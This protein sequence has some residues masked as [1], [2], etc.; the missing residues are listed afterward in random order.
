MGIALVEKLPAAERDLTYL[1]RVVVICLH[2]A[3]L[4]T[5]LLPTISEAES[6]HLHKSTYRLVHLGVRGRAGRS[7][8]HLACARD[9]ALVGR[10]PAC[11]FPSPA[12]ADLLL[13]VG[14]DVNVS[15]MSN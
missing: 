8:L 10:Y 6:F 3:C 13:T 1:H 7:V 9:S 4:L 5:K 14:A 15:I 11:Q 12:L 2:L